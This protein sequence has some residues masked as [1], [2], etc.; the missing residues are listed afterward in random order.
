MLYA[1]LK[2]GKVSKFQGLC[3]NYNRNCKNILLK[4]ILEVFVQRNRCNFGLSMASAFRSSVGPQDL[5]ILNFNY[6]ERNKQ[7]K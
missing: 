3:V 5:K 2:H 7:Q 6:Y 1:N 4:F